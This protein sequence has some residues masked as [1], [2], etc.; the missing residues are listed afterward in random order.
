MN[1]AFT[2][3]PTAVVHGRL[4]V[5]HGPALQSLAFME[6][7]RSTLMGPRDWF[8]GMPS[9]PLRRVPKPK[10]SAFNNLSVLGSGRDVRDYD[11]RLPGYES[12]EKT[13]HHDQVHGPTRDAGCRRQNDSAP[14]QHLDAVVLLFDLPRPHRSPAATHDLQAPFSTAASGRPSRDGHT[15]T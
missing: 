1:R 13:E 5:I 8:F 6:S 12:C 2:T 14:T 3:A 9:W 15:G 7:A 4:R 11:A 10:P